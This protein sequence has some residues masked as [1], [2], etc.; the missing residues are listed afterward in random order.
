MAVWF[1]RPITPLPALL[2]SFRWLHLRTHFQIPIKYIINRHP[3]RHEVLIGSILGIAC[4]HIWFKNV[5]I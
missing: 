2:H 1:G 3:I 5:K 4:S